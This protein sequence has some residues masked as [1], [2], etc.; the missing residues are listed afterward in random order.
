M[1]IIPGLEKYNFLLL[2]QT[3]QLWI[4][5]GTV[6]NTPRLC[7]CYTLTSL[8]IWELSVQRGVINEG[9]NSLILLCFNGAVHRSLCWRGLGVTLSDL[10][11][12]TFLISTI[13]P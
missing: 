8:L 1:A 5:T 9:C 12:V 13:M 6:F 2:L 11:F 3:V 10:A 4:S 7:R